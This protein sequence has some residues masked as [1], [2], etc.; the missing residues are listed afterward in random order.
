M[1]K[2]LL[3]AARRSGTTL[4]IDCLNQHP[5]IQC[6]KRAFGLERKI[7]DPTPDKHSGAFYLYRTRSLFNRTRYVMRRNRLIYDFLSEEVLNPQQN[8]SAIGFRLTYDMLSKYP[9]MI[10]WSKENDIQVIHLVR[11]NILKTYIST[12]SA[13]IHKMHHPRE[14]DIINAT[15]IRIDPKDLLDILSRRTLEIEKRRQ[16]FSDC[17]YHELGYEKLV[18]NRD[19][20]L[21]KIQGLLVPGMEQ[22][23]TSDLA[24]IN[25]E[26]LAETIEN[27]HE[28]RDV[29]NGTPYEKFLE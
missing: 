19:E 24:K 27:F 6:M 4:L 12:V 29:L 7:S 20:E 2:F 17:T 18:S 16:Q 11:H 28:I 22:Q 9:Q 26:S 10:E 14:G 15:K 25:P 13:P 1:T 3:L 23:L 8:I 5:E 21:G